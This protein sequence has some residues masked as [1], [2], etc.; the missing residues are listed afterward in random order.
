MNMLPINGEWKRR[1]KWVEQQRKQQMSVNKSTGQS[2]WIKQTM[3][4][5]AQIFH[6]GSG[7]K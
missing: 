1:I 7:R 3:G 5:E 4:S 2:K 6:A